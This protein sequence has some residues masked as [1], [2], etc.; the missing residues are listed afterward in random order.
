MSDA[1]RPRDGVTVMAPTVTLTVTIVRSGE[2]SGVAPRAGD[3]DLRP[4]GQGAWIARMVAELGASAKVC[5]P[6][7]GRS[8]AILRPLIEAE[9]LELHATPVHRANTVWVSDG[10]D[11]AAATIAETDSQVLDRHEVDDLLNTT[12]AC[13][14]GSR[15][16]VLAG[17]PVPGMI[18]ADRYATLTRNLRRNGVIV[19]TDLSRELILPVAA[20]GADVMKVS[21]EDVVGIGLATDASEAALTSAAKALL[22]RGAGSVIVS[23]AERPSIAVRPGSALRLCPPPL[24]PVNPKGAGDAMTGAIAAALAL[25]RAWSEA[26]PLAAAAGTLNVARRGL[27]TGDRA[28]IE[29]LAERIVLEPLPEVPTG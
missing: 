9:G 27:G 29:L 15:V 25:G 13:A 14:L 22:S 2:A 26:I 23:R 10:P 19:V 20:A 11:G 1:A 8:G 21:H 16:C 18:D 6:L 17:V 5:G 12:L 4:G 3:I 24:E 28:A 7:G